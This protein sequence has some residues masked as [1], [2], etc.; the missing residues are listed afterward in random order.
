[1]LLEEFEPILYRS[2]AIL[3]R[4]CHYLSHVCVELRLPNKAAKYCKKALRCVEEVYPG[5]HTET[6]MLHH[7]LG[8][9]AIIIRVI[10]SVVYSNTTADV[11]C[12]YARIRN[13]CVSLMVY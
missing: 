5:M 12:M 7:L 13:M 8:M 9:W 11:V 3:Y 2:H 4:A 1:M 10:T 6:A